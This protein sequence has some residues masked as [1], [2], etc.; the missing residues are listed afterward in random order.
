[1]N[2]LTGVADTLRS[3]GSTNDWSANA[4]MVFCVII[5]LII[6]FSNRKDNKEREAS[7]RQERKDFLDTLERYRITIERIADKMDNIRD[8]I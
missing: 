7:Y 5:V 2:D 6:Y 1:M 4:A 3:I 8:K